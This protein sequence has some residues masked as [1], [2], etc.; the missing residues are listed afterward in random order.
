MHFDLKRCIGRMFA[1]DRYCLLKS[2][3]AKGLCTVQVKM[4]YY[5][6]VVLTD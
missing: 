2:A 1:I 6:S 5:I 3:L 4:T